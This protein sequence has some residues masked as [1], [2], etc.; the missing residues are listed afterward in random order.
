MGFARAAELTDVRLLAGLLLSRA[1]RL[2]KDEAISS[3]VALLCAGKLLAWP[4]VLDRAGSP[5]ALKRARLFL[6]ASVE[7]NPSLANV[8]LASGMN[9]HVLVRHFRER[10]GATPHSYLVM[11]KIARAKEMLSRGVGAAGVAVMLG[12]ADQAH[13]TRTF[14]SSV[15]I[16]PAAYQRRVRAVF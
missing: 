11:A 8:A 1:T 15:G 7:A 14:R 6:D 12:F 3:L 10:F 13:F 9:K 4:E 2:E 5:V 16:P